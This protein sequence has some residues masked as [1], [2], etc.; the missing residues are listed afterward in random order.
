M[1]EVMEN[2][3]DSSG[4]ESGLEFAGPEA[5]NISGL[6]KL[7]KVITELKVPKN[8]Y[9]KFG[10]FKYRTLDDIID[11]LRPLC[12]KYGI[13][14]VMRDNVI[15]VEGRWYLVSY[16]HIYDVDT[17]ALITVGQG[18]AR[19]ASQK[20]KFD[21]AQLSGSASTYARKYALCGV[22]D[23]AEGTDED[24]ISGSESQAKATPPQDT[25][26]PHNIYSPH[27]KADIVELLEAHRQST[28]VDIPYDD[29]MRVLYPNGL[30]P[31]SIDYVFYHF[32]KAIITYNRRTQQR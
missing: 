14:Y 29:F 4:N 28:N 31:D 8:G 6:R 9:N 20:A 26:Q 7:Q 30:E 19:E 12:L 1:D 16:V 17:G 3:T 13:V 21:E 5:P 10:G 24:S 25:Q 11:G 15:H 18:W 27:T 23:I 2:L 22:F 32:A